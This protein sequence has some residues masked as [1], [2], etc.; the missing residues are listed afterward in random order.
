MKSTTLYT[1]LALAGA[2]PFLACALLPLMGV[3]ALEPIGSLDG[4]ASSYGLSIISFLAGI[5]WA[6]YL[7]KQ[8]QVRTNLFVTSNV[9]FL[10]VWIAFVVGGLKVALA[11]QIIAFV[12][13]MWV[14]RGLLRSMVISNTYFRMRLIVTG[15]VVLS[16]SIIWLRIDG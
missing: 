4:L 6:T 15:L 1:T 7:L 2:L 10:G 14:D 5:H 8:D 16:L 11:S 12:Y 9:V 13:L 3:V